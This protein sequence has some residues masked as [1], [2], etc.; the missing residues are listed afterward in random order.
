MKK[1]RE[2]KMFTQ[3]QEDVGEMRITYR[4]EDKWVSGWGSKQL[5]EDLM[6]CRKRGQTEL[7][8]TLVD[9]FDEIWEEQH[10]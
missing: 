5:Y 3:W 6:Y 7:P 1:Y 8:K 9:Y 2:P 10:E 4:R